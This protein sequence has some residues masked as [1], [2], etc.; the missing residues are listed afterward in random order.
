MN[1]YTD[2]DGNRLGVQVIGRGEYMEF[3]MNDKKILVMIEILHAEIIGSS[4]TKWEDGKRIKPADRPHILSLIKKG[5]EL[6][7]ARG[8]EVKIV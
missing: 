1:Y 3:E 4:V 7:Y 2:N 5:Y 6:F 8:A